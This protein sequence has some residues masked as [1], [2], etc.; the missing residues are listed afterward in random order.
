[1]PVLLNTSFNNNCEPIVDSIEDALTCFLTTGLDYLV[2][3]D[4][5]I[6]KRGDEGAAEGML[7]LVPIRAMWLSDFKGDGE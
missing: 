6:S 5:V 3:D 4:L 2:A 1:M 7:G